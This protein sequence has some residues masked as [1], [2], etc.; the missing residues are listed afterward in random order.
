MR[1]P[2]SSVGPAVKAGVHRSPLALD[3]LERALARYPHAARG[4]DEV[5]YAPKTGPTRAQANFRT[6]TLSVFDPRFGEDPQYD[7]RMI[8]HEFGHFRQRADPARFAAEIS[9]PPT[10]GNGSMEDWLDYAASPGE[11][12]AEGFGRALSQETFDLKEKSQLPLWDLEDNAKLNALQR[13]L[14]V[15]ALRG[16]YDTALS[17]RGPL[18]EWPENAP[19]QL[20][21]LR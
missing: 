9:S 5:T 2:I 18:P 4:I 15:D 6:R 19:V 11:L 10:G 20:R 16:E 7:A 13:A 8:G 3:A 17:R 14:E 21:L 12:D 1:I